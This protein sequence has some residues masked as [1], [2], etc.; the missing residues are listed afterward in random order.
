MS[1]ISV[2]ASSQ[3]DGAGGGGNSNTSG[4][5]KA[6]YS[7]SGGQ[8]LRISLFMAPRGEGVEGVKDI[9]WNGDEVRQ[10]MDLY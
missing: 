6:G 9:N 4:N 5:G 2:F 3:S 8:F 7:W 10:V 1:S